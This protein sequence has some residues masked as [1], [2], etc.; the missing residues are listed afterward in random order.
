MVMVQAVCV[1]VL[2]LEQVC[3]SAGITAVIRTDICVVMCSRCQ[4]ERD[5]LK[6]ANVNKQSGSSVPLLPPGPSEVTERKQFINL[7]HNH[8]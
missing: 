1:S 6:R 4:E 3:V 5:H 7:H 8:T 2:V